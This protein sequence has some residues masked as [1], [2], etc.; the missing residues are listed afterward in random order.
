MGKSK[1]V[2]VL[3]SGGLDSTY[4]I[5]KN[6]KEGNTVVPFYF[7]IENNGKK[8]MLEK[9]RIE[10]LRN[11]FNEEFDGKVE[12]INY[13]LK[14]QVI[15]SSSTLHFKQ[16]P[17]WILGLLFGQDK[18]LSEI[19]IGYVM[20][21]DAVSYLDDIKKIYESYSVISDELISITFPLYKYKK[22]QMLEELPE[23]NLK[24]KSVLV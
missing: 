24:S 1:K 21:D 18:G 9:N 4:L 20:N 23:I 5:W 14:I 19:Q 11:E 12:Y 13:T 3:F 17:I 22:W 10:L 8:P 2:G 15:E 16:I 7:E 6:L